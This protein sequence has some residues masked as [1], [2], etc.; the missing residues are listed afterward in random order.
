MKYGTLEFFQILI[1]LMFIHKKGILSKPIHFVAFTF[2]AMFLMYSINSLLPI[3][4]EG[5]VV[6]KKQ[7]NTEVI[8]F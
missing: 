8:R 4:V 6:V 3:L 5:F 7:M 2:F 1:C